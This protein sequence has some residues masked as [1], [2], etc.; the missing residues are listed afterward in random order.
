MYARIR[1][2]ADAIKRPDSMVSITS[3]ENNVERTNNLNSSL[4]AL[5]G[6][7]P[8]SLLQPASPSPVPS[9]GVAQPN[10]LNSSNA[11]LASNAADA[12]ADARTSK[13]TEEARRASRRREY[14][15]LYY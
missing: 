14:E 10:N 11:A 9:V 3:S 8:H 15:L 12:G 6:R 1:I 5:G 13:E 2:T 4:P 7:D